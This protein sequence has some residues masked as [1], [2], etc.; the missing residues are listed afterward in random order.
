MMRHQMNEARGVMEGLGLVTGRRHSQRERGQALVEFA[1]VLP[2][3]MLIFLGIIQFG[4][5][6]S[7]HIG[8]INGVRETARYGSTIPT[9]TG[10]TGGS[11]NTYMTGTVMP[12]HVAGY[13]AA[14]LLSSSATFC[15]Y[16]D[17]VSKWHVRMTVT[18]QYAHPLFIPLVG[19][20]VDGIDGFNDQAFR[21]T[22]LES[23]RIENPPLSTP[24]AL[25]DC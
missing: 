20:L 19:V 4:F 1:L 25:P 13:R 10:S 2:V 22:V 5:L 23:M 9:T 17:S 11:I 12:R 15:R 14:N 8:L 24:P 6:F 21:L 3:F 7:G 16:Q 18:A